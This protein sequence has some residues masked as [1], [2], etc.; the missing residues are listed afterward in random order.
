MN[1]A[2]YGGK[3][4]RIGG[5]EPRNAP[6]TAADTFSVADA[7]LF[8]P[9]SRRWE[10][11][12]SLPEPRSSHD[13]V[14]IGSKLIVTGGWALQGKSGQKWMGTLQVLDLG[15]IHPAWKSASQPFKRRAL[16]AAAYR[17]KMYVMGG[18]TDKSEIVPD[19][20][21]YDPRS[22][23]W[24]KGPPLPGTAANCFAPAATVHEGHL[25]VSLANGSLYRLNDAVQRWEE[26]G[27]ATP[28]VAHRLVSGGTALLVIGGAADGNNF[29]LI[30]ALNR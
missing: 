23:L 27:H 20:D 24:T 3:I 22:G 14:V 1:L 17:G 21:I 19:V 13:F 26:A 16:I 30:E 4:Y 7:A 8:D 28:R 9:A 2:A 25:Y 29:D 6:G 12:P 11:L 5:M 18:M 15:A 10:S